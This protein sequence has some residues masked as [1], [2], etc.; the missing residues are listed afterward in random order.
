[1][2]RFQCGRS[3][4]SHALKSQPHGPW[5]R[6]RP[7]T[8]IYVDV[9]RRR[10]GSARYPWLIRAESEPP[11]RHPLL[12]QVPIR[13]GSAHLERGVRRK[14][15]PGQILAPLRPGL[16]DLSAV[17]CLPV[18]PISTSRFPSS[19]MGLSEHVTRERLRGL[20]GLQ[21][22]PDRWGRSEPPGTYEE[23]PGSLW[24]GAAPFHPKNPGRLSFFSRILTGEIQA[25]W[26][27][28]RSASRPAG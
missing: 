13:I 19:N 11:G 23:V 16:V 21:S 2:V 20:L 24:S 26:F 8:A 6:R 9:A 7:S 12:R 5:V 4:T 14:R 28:R 1:M 27:T 15:R 3:Y 22:T 17:K 10:A 18:R 25:A